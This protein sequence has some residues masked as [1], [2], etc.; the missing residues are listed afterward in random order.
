MALSNFV[1]LLEKIWID[2]LKAIFEFFFS[3][4]LLDDKDWVISIPIAFLL[5]Y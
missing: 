3:P 4:L 5:K 2:S 1:R